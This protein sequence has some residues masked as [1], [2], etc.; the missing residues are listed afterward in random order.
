[1]ISARDRFAKSPSMTERQ[2][3]LVCLLPECFRRALHRSCNFFDLGLA[4]R[5]CPQFLNILL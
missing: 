1:M 3:K 2:A 4:S 5:V